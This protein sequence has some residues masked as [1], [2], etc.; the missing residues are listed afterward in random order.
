MSSRALTGR[1]LVTK[2]F[3]NYRWVQN[4]AA[5]GPWDLS[6]NDYQW[7]PSIGAPRQT[8][9]LYS[10]TF[11]DFS[12]YTQDDLTVY[13]E[14]VTIQEGGTF[15]VIEDAASIQ[16]GCMVLDM[17]TEERI[18]NYD[19][20]AENVA[21]LA[22]SPS[23][24]RGPLEFQQII[25]GQY[26]MFGADTSIW[27]NT[28]GVL[29]LLDSNQF[30]SGSPTTVE[31]LWCYRFI[32]PLGVFQADPLA[33]ICVPPSRVVMSINVDKESELEY[34]MRLKRSYELGTAND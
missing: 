15:R 33:E 28:Q 6:K 7:R 30:G 19:T 22:T 8:G 34:M 2:E 12:G 20:V 31:K 1:R 24:S 26:R 17:L 23:F 32:I 11:I 16:K 3:M 13:P 5:P 4:A 18:T 27:T 14:R 9:Y 25:F 21:L 29:T 10:E